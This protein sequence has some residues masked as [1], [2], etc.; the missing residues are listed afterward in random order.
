MK[1]L[2]LFILIFALIPVFT[3][4]QTIQQPDSVF[5][6]MPLYKGYGITIDSIQHNGNWIDKMPRYKSPNKEWILQNLAPL[7]LWNIKPANSIT[8]CGNANNGSFTL[9]FKGDSLISSGTLKPDEGAKL[10]IKY[11]QSQFKTKV[12]SLEFELKVYKQVES[13][14]LRDLLQSQ[15]M[16]KAYKHSYEILDK[17]YDKIYNAYWTTLCNLQKILK[18]YHENI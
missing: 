9:T 5:D 2:K 4:G 8:F 1:T 3:Q 13:N 6:H 11:C 16:E 10:F 18:N 17:A 12:D 15:K 14:L 7:E